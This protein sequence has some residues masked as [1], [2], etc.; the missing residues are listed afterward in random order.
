MGILQSLNGGPAPR[1]QPTG[2]APFA[3]PRERDRQALFWWLKRNISY[4]AIE[5]NSKLW[6]EFLAEWEKWLRGMADPSE[7]LTDTFKYALDT[8]LFYERG[9]TRLRLGDRSVFDRKSSEGWLA[10]VHTALVERRMEWDGRCELIAQQDGVPLR[11]SSAT[12][13]E[14]G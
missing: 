12:T 14:S 10:K 4:I 3:Q 9:L 2:P 1:L 13:S 8:Q 6:T 7:H 5:H 11:S